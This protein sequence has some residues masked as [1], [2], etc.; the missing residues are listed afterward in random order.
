MVNS[1]KKHS[2][3]K[4]NWEKLMSIRLKSHFEAKQE[5]WRILEVSHLGKQD[6]DEGVFTKNLKITSSSFLM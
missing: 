3:N 6:G 2:T 5:L 1:L 4:F